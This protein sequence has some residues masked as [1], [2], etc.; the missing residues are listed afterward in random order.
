MKQAKPGKAKSGA[1]GDIL[2]GKGDGTW[3]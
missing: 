3:S 2:I 1:G